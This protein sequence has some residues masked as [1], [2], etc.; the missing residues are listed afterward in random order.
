MNNKNLFIYG[1]FFLPLNLNL[2]FDFSMGA[3]C[4]KGGVYIAPTVQS[5]LN[6][7]LKDE[8]EQLASYKRP[9]PAKPNFSPSSHHK[10][11]PFTLADPQSNFI[12]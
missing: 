2:L 8:D 9:T 1:Y 11:L 3:G 7:I 5:R 12:E 10:E 6:E 4:T